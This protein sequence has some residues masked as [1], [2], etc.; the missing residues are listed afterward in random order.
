MTFALVLLKGQ[1]LIPRTFYCKPCGVAV[2]EAISESDQI[3]SLFQELGSGTT[4]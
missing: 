2:I 4:S 3:G 1:S